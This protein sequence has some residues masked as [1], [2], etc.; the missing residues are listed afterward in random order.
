MELFYQILVIM[1][2]FVYLPRKKTQSCGRDKMHI[3]RMTSMP[4]IAL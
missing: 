1:E 4:L 3:A 2:M